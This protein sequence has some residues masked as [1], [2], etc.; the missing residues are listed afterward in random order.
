MGSEEGIRKYGEISQEVGEWPP[1]ELQEA[2]SQMAG[3]QKKAV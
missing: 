3:G 1:V 2:S